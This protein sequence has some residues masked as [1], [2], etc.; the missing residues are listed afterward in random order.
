MLPLL[1]NLSLGISI[2]E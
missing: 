1:P 2:P